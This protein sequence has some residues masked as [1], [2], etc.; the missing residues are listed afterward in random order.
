[1][2]LPFAVVWILTSLFMFF[3]LALIFWFWMLVDLLQRK[4]EDKL[5]WVIVLIFLNIIGAILYYFLVY[6]KSGKARKGKK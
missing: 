4:I 6:A 3:L 1:M 5:V 2:C